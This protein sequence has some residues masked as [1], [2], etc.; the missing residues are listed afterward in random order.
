[1]A[2]FWHDM[3]GLNWTPG[4]SHL[5]ATY[6][7]LPTCRLLL[8]VWGKWNDC[9]SSR[10]LSSLPG[11]KDQNS[12]VLSHPLFYNL[13]S[14][15][16]FS[17][18]NV[19]V[20]ITLLTASFFLLSSCLILLTCGQF[21]LRHGEH[22]DSAITKLHTSVPL[23]HAGWARNPQVQAAPPL[24]VSPN[25]V[26]SHLLNHSVVIESWWEA[27]FPSRIIPLLLPRRW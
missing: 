23:A 2:H 14:F 9:L 24:I 25:G 19:T 26:C 12:M 18:M 15:L 7:H 1:M 3:L 16:H 27:G 8:W 22:L 20:L 5:Y 11:G 21:S 6:V 10:C 17:F 13:L 4:Q